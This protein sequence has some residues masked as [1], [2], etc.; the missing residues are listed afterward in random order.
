MRQVLL[1]AVLS[2]CLP[3]FGRALEIN[4]RTG[5]YEDIV[6]AIH[7]A[8][9]YDERIIENIKALF[10]SA[11]SFL[12]RATRGLVHFGSVTIAVPET[13]PQRSQATATTASLFPVADVRVAAENPQYGDTPYT[14]QPR[15][16]GERGEYIHLTPRFLAELNGSMAEI[17]GSPAY[18]LVHEWAHFRYGVFDEYGD[19]ESDLYPSLYCES[20]MVLYSVPIV[21][22]A[23][24]R[25]NARGVEFFVRRKR[26]SQLAKA[27]L[28]KDVKVN[29][30]EVQKRKDTLGRVIFALDV[31]SSMIIFD[32][33]A[34]VTGDHKFEIIID[35]DLGKEATIT[36]LCER[37]S[38]LF[39]MLLYPGGRVC[40]A[41]RP[42]GPSTTTDTYVTIKIPGVAMPGTWT[43]VTSHNL[44]SS[45]TVH[46]HVRAMALARESS[47]EPVMARAFLKRTEVGRA[48]E[49][50]VYAEVSKG[51][52]AV[53][54]ARVMATIIRPQKP[55]EVV[56]EL[57][58]NGVAQGPAKGT[59]ATLKYGV[60]G[61]PLNRF[62]Y[63]DQN[64]EAAEPNLVQAEKSPQFSRYVEAGSFR[65]TAHIDESSIPPG[66]IHD[67]RVEDAFISVGATR[68]VCWC[69]PAR[70]P[71]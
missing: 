59:V 37:V 57:F 43:L 47:V 66:S 33:A 4:K 18:Q 6:V 10:S 3:P 27:D 52:H 31:S 70:E 41:C 56:V 2:L 71:T 44:G 35:E 26:I 45:N 20:G 69:G 46:V 51:P 22:Y 24:S 19:P 62:L 65:L 7:P 64:A 60:G 36:V 67:L 21:I 15:G 38:I 5:G 40:D 42:L 25:E 54:H 29:F 17:Y 28:G 55:Y 12:H 16:C 34:N 9:S 63:V 8:V 1:L 49:A 50:V 14:L 58:D 68:F 32:G 23:S 13:W 30:K 39:F 11:S 53:L 48:E 61:I